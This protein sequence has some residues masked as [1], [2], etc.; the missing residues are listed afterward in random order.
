MATERRTAPSR[1]LLAIADRRLGAV[2]RGL[3]PAERDRYLG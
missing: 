3:T 2:G 1:R